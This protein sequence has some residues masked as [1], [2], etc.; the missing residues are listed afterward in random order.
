MYV[1]CTV[2]FFDPYKKETPGFYKNSINFFFIAQF[3][4]NHHLMFHYPPGKRE[5]AR[6]STR[7]S[8][9][10]HGSFFPCFPGL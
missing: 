2:I 6:A 9:P 4:I 7:K 5:R 1:T 10:L 3:S 8:F